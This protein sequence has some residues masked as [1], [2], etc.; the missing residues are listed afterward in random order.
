MKTLLLA[1]SIVLLFGFNFLKNKTEQTE[2]D[3]ASDDIRLYCPAPL[4]FSETI[5]CSM[6]KVT[7]VDQHSIDHN[8][9]N[10]AIGIINDQEYNI[11]YSDKLGAFQSPNRKNNMRF[12]YHKDGFTA[13]S[14]DTRRETQDVKNDWSIDLRIKKEGLG[15]M[16]GDLIADGNKSSIENENIRIDYTNTKEG[17][18]QDFIIKTKPKEEGKLRLNISADTKL[19]MIAGADALMF[20]DNKGADMMK[21][22]SLKCWDA[23]GVELRAYFEKNYKLQISNDKLQKP[24]NSDEVTD[25][26]I[27]NLKFDICNSFSI[28]VNDE[29]AT[30]PITIDPLSTSADWT[31]ESDQ[32]DAQFGYSV[33]TA[34][35]V[36]GDGYS[37]VI[38]GAPYFDNGVTDA[39]KT[40]VYYGSITGLSLSA[41][42]TTEGNSNAVNLGTSVSTAGDVNG[43]GYSDVIVG[44]ASID[45]PWLQKNSAA[46]ENL[47]DVYFTSTSK[48]WASGAGGTIVRTTDSGENWS[49]QNSGT[50][51]DLRSI[52]FTSPNTGWAVGLT[53]VIRITTNAGGSWLFQTSGT[54]A[55]LSCVYFRTST[56]GWIAGQSGIIKKTT[57]AGVNWTAQTSGLTA[58]LRDIFFTSATEGYIVGA[59][60]KIIKTTN[61][62]VNWTAQTSGTT[63]TLRAIYFS[64][65]TT[66]WAFGHAGTIL[67][68]TNGG[69]SWTPQTSGTT[70]DLYACYFTS[71]T[72]GWTTGLGGTILK[73]TDGGSNWISRNGGA[74]GDMRSIFF[75]APDSGIAVGSFGVICKYKASATGTGGFTNVY[76]GSASGLSPSVSSILTSGTGSNSTGTV[77][78]A[79]GDINGDGYG[80][81][82]IS[83]PLNPGTGNVF[84]HYGSASGLQTTPNQTLTGSQTSEL[85]GCSVS[86]SGDVDGDGYSDIIVGSSNFMVGHGTNGKAFVYR[87][88]ASGIIE[89]PYWSKEGP[90]FDP[91][92]GYSVST[93]G[94]V[95]GDGYSDIVV[96][97]PQNSAPHWGKA[98][99]YHGSASGISATENWSAEYFDPGAKFGTSVSTAGD[100]NG[101]GFADVIVGAPYYDN[102]QVD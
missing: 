91:Q 99:V 73:T 60:G 93:A 59:T 15:I 85:F 7:S 34:G 88:S 87:G 78:S 95:N 63:Q 25:N 33:S 8:W 58:E 24:N 37:D 53:G 3:P 84:I 27:C 22:S 31:A 44:A 66:G 18:R 35:D 90:G 98:F 9:Y 67:Y 77:V 62:G 39:G 81:A 28:V 80:D 45:P 40:F 64:S 47:Q 79:A 29:D 83:Y 48:G 21:Y 61:G 71:P 38:V 68:T 17:M 82:L 36:N 30:Y 5:K 96:G 57:N 94:D 92:Y 32:S 14:R 10:E 86:T 42:W 26:T 23:N 101:D 6:N 1:I 69:T 76:H 56:E 49:V 70:Q 41:N 43:D 72:N 89:A 74:G 12:I 4:S 46:V 13:V 50:S 16:N 52:F 2:I 100:I 65:S 11:S 102:G 75:S 97:S 54:T 55:N 51:A 19:K 20:K